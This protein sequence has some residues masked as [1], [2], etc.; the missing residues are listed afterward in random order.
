MVLINP[1]FLARG[2][3]QGRE[4]GQDVGAEEDAPQQGGS[5]L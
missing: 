5:T 2:L 4:S 3:Q 1:I